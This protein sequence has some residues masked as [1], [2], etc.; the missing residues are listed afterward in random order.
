MFHLG[1]FVINFTKFEN[2][3]LLSSSTKALYMMM[4]VKFNFDPIKNTFE[5][6]AGYKREILLKYFKYSNAIG[7]LDIHLGPN[8]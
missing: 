4:R 6:I 3:F 7:I 1:K 2:S 5:N 8:Y